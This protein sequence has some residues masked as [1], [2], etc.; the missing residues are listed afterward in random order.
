MMLL[1]CL[2]QVGRVP[3]PKPRRSDTVKDHH[4]GAAQQKALFVRT[5]CSFCIPKGLLVRS[6]GD[7]QNHGFYGYLQPSEK[8]LLKVLKVCWQK[9]KRKEYIFNAL[10]EKKSLDPIYGCSLYVLPGKRKHGIAQ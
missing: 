4:P 8:C 6:R 10:N 1:R 5:F 2:D 9:S 3:S 7:I